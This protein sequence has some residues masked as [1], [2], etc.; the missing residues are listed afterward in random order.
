LTLS[1][2]NNIRIAQPTTAAQYFHLLRSQVHRSRPTPLI[3]FTPK[4]MLRAVQTR[5]PLVEFEQG[6]FRSVLDDTLD[7]ASLV[8]RAVLASGKIAHEV[9]AR[10]NETE[11]TS[12]AVIRVEQLYPWPRIAIDETLARYPN[13]QEIFWLQEEPENMGAWPFVHLQM[14]SQFRGM[15]VGHV[16]RAESAS[17]ATGSG[18]IHGAEQ[19]DLVARALG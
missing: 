14:H 8:T 6:S 1:A 17:P 2:R 13:L 3:V 16:A 5:S 7:D 12:A 11:T 19:A 9:I 10:R 18:L 15:T 4:S